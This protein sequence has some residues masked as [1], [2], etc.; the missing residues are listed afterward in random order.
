MAVLLTTPGTHFTKSTLP[1][2]NV[3]ID[4]GSHS[5]VLNAIHLCLFEIHLLSTVN[6]SFKQGIGKKYSCVLINVQNTCYS[7]PG[8][9]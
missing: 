5:N 9:H 2:S 6:I 1:C 3:D 4:H 8:F 7:V